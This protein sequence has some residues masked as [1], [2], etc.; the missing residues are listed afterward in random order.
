MAIQLTTN[1]TGLGIK[2]KAVNSMSGTVTLAGA[3]PVAVANTDILITDI[4]LFGI[5]TVGGTPA[6]YSYSI[7]AGTGFTITG[8]A[9][10]TS[11]L[12]YVIIRNV[13]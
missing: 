10:D 8:T 13:A 4:V 2:Q 12:N 9:G 6:A 11:V 7:T 1:F 3:T 5:N